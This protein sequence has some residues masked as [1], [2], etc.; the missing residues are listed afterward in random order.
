M[1]LWAVAVWITGNSTIFW[2]STFF[3]REEKRLDWIAPCV[4][5][6]EL[7]LSPKFF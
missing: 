4:H 6:E 3:G 7:R 5:Y 1:V 2:R